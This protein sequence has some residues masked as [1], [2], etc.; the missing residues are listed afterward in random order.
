MV[1]LGRSREQPR[2]DRVRAGGRR[3][4]AAPGPRRAL[5]LAR[6]GVEYTKSSTLQYT[7][8]LL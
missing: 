3:K 7:T 4:A 5:G 2:P 8:P 1:L 6:L